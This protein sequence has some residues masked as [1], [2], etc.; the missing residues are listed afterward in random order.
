MC[1]TG[2]REASA[3]VQ[4]AK[5]IVL[6]GYANPFT[7]HQG[8]PPA[9]G[10]D[11]SKDA[12]Q[13][14]RLPGEEEEGTAA[15]CSKAEEAAVCPRPGVAAV[16][17][18]DPPPSYSS[19]VGEDDRD[20]SAGKGGG[21]GGRGACGGV[22]PSQPPESRQQQHSGP[23]QE[24][25]PAYLNRL[26][27]HEPPASSSASAPSVGRGAGSGAEDHYR[28]LARSVSDRRILHDGRNSVHPVLRHHDYSLTRPYSD[29]SALSESQ[30]SS[31]RIDK[32]NKKLSLKSLSFAGNTISEL[33]GLNGGSSGGGS[34]SNSRSRKSY[35]AD[36]L[37]ESYDFSPESRSSKT[38]EAQPEDYSS[39]HGV[40]PEEISRGNVVR[41]DVA[42]SPIASSINVAPSS[43]EKSRALSAKFAM[44]A[45]P[46]AG[47]CREELTTSTFTAAP[48]YPNASDEA[49]VQGPDRSVAAS[50]SRSCRRTTKLS[51]S[52]ER[53]ILTTTDKHVAQQQPLES[54]S[55]ENN[56]LNLENRTCIRT[57]KKNG[58]E[59][60][61]IEF[62]TCDENI[63][64]VR[65]SRNISEAINENRSEADDIPVTCLQRRGSSHGT[66]VVSSRNEVRPELDGELS[67]LAEPRN[68]ARNNNNPFYECSNSDESESDASNSAS[69]T[70]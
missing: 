38:A 19:V 3:H 50:S 70:R 68:K 69:M 37:Y 20:T 60:D 67:S 17:R 40:L 36:S 9:G 11:C 48:S 63:T 43:N 56:N 18:Y 31:L 8:P 35:R 55:S 10:G 46:T 62:D 24:A 28:G 14:V 4:R 66:D 30:M 41:G 34:S 7:P 29:Y 51:K 23:I 25:Y 52:V 26:S 27:R 16:S 42:P 33:F 22:T 64:E 15:K 44:T 32:P 61:L 57:K 59:K 54:S 13:F 6:S 5:E 39:I 47:D 45:P 58:N 21:G 12:P 2:A 53:S 1:V 65:N 49:A